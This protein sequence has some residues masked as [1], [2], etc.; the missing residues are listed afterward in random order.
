MFFFEKKNQKTFATWLG[1]SGKHP[2]QSA[3]VLC[4]FSLEKTTFLCWDV[5]LTTPP[6]R[7]C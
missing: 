6:K 5:L 1:G 4:F 2:R 3:K 7:P